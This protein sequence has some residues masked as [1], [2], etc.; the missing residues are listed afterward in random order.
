M[1][2]PPK[3]HVLIRADDPQHEPHRNRELP[4]SRIT[5][6]LRCR[7]L[8]FFPASLQFA[9]ARREHVLHPFGLAA[10]GERDDESIRHSKDVHWGSVGLPRL[11]TN[12]RENAEPGSQ[13]ANRLVSLFVKAILIFASHRLRNRIISTPE[14]AMTMIMMAPALNI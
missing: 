4:T 13:P 5:H 7:K 1:V 6:D 11:A 2:L 10:V 8:M 14:A 3:I 9:T 12:V